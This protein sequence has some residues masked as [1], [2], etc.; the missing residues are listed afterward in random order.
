MPRVLTA[1]TVSL[2]V[3]ALAG[4]G[5]LLVSPP[6]GS[7]SLAGSFELEQ[8]ALR[9]SELESRFDSLAAST[10]SGPVIVRAG[11][12]RVG[13]DGGESGE[14]TREDDARDG[15]ESPDLLA[16][17]EVLET[18]LRGL[19]EDPIQRAFTYLQSEN[20]GLRRRGVHDLENLAKSDPEALRAVRE[21]AAD[22]DPG[23]RQ[24][25]LD[26]L[27]DI[28][29]K[30]AIPLAAN[31]LD[32]D[33]LD[34]RR[35]AINTLM[36]LESKD[37]AG[38]IASFLAD[39][40]TK[41]RY[42]AADA[43]GKLGYDASA[44]D[45]VSLLADADAG[46]RGQAISSLGEIGATNA[47]PQLRDLYANV[48]AEGAK[49]AGDHRF[50][51]ARAMKQLGDPAAIQTEVSRLGETALDQAANPRARHGALRAL[52]YYGRDEPAAKKIFEQAAKDGTD[53]VRREAQR[54]LGRGRERGERGRRG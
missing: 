4:V 15:G 44:S 48:T 11:S 52:M 30:E 27:A 54:A 7:A 32:D 21:M 13:E 34:V 3:L 33:S 50:R 22:P 29:D 5:Y 43:M 47:L 39:E 23:V 19:E 45:L 20:P 26:T 1:L 10:G 41:S 51:L 31:L 42:M 6:A 40:D 24:A 2:S 16:R 35:E 28:S 8:M 17:L 37:H 25:V 46:V 14:A 18:R 38:A 9:L 53:W 49:N 12:G 36:R